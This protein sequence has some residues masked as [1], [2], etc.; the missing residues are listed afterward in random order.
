MSSEIGMRHG[1][2]SNGVLGRIE[3]SLLLSLADV[4]LVSNAFVAE[5]VAH[6]ADAD[7]AL[8]RELLLGLLARIGVGEVRVEVGVEDLLGLLREVASLAA[9]VQEARA[10]DHDEL[11]GA[12]F[13]LHLDRAEVLADDC[14]HTVDFACCYWAS[15]ALV[16]Q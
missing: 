6:L 7:A 5:P 15:V 2:T 1:G 10:K 9:R 16:A 11:A 3:R 4:L 8:S 12:L 13:E 14:H